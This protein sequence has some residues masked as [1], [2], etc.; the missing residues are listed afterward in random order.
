LGGAFG[1]R[2][3]GGP[4][5]VGDAVEVL[6]GTARALG[7]QL[8]VGRGQDAPY[9]PGRCAVLLLGGE[10]IGAAGELHPRVVSQLGLPPRTVVGELDLDRLVAAAAQAGPAVAP[11]VSSY[12]PS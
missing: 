6:L 3:A 9:H 2:R 1:G 4:V 8:A 11:I 12:P 5:A 10:P 7:L